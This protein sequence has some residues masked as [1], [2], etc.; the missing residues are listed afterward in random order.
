MSERNGGWITIRMRGEI[1]QEIGQTY[2]FVCDKIIGGKPWF[3][4]FAFGDGNPYK[5]GRFWLHKDHDLVFRTYIGKTPEQVALEQKNLEK[6]DNLG[7]KRNLL[8]STDK[9]DDIARLPQSQNPK[10]LFQ[11]HHLNP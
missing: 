5:P 6:I 10:S 3:G 7:L 8:I 1:E 11:T 4:A 2:F 9:L